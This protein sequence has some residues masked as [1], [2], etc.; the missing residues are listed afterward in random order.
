VIALN[1]HDK[2]KRS[3]ILELTTE[4]KSLL[5]HG[6]K[7]EA[8]ACYNEMLEKYPDEETILYGKGMIY[9]EFDDYQNALECFNEVL[10]KQPSNVDSLYAKS[11]VLRLLGQLEDALTI[12]D[13]VLA[14]NPKMVLAYLTKGYILIDMNQFDE[15]I[16]NFEKVEKFGREEEVLAG[17]GYCYLKLNE[18]DK[19]NK[20]YNTALQIDPYDPE[21]LFGKG[22]LEHHYKNWK[23]AE[24]YLY[25]CVVQ[26]EVNLDAWKLLADVY[27]QTKQSKKEEIAREKIKELQK[28][29]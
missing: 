4:A 1:K 18:F 20:L 8:L 12:I 22:F 17:K 7:E 9:F 10:K 19:A 16:I 5:A 13:Q 11:S 23:H 2:E 6:K 29:S 26:D 28:K 21:A 14:L 27:K 15:A 24:N 3:F 25:R